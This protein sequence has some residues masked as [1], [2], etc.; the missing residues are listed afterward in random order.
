MESF[1]GDFSIEVFLNESEITSFVESFTINEDCVSAVP[2]I[3]L[4][5]KS[6]ASIDNALWDGSLISII[7][8]ASKFKESYGFM[9]TDY[10]MEQRDGQYVY[11]VNGITFYAKLFDIRIKSYP[12]SAVSSVLK[13]ICNEFKMESDL[14]QTIDS[15]TWLQNNISTM[16]F[17][18]DLTKYSYRNSSSCIKC[19]LS[20]TGKLYLKDL[21]EIEDSKFNENNVIDDNSDMFA[22]SDGEDSSGIFARKYSYGGSL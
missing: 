20:R 22:I 1:S 10:D 12:N 4:V 9:L 15:Q 17:I 18:K 14:I 7:A 3:Q 16:D 21:A 6:Q 8:Q 19:C 2:D 11:T 5:L 13:N